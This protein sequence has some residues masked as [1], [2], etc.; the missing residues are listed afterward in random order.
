MLFV[1]EFLTGIDVM[2]LDIDGGSIMYALTPHPVAGLRE[3]PE[4]SA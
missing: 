4:E 2:I 1:A 3:L